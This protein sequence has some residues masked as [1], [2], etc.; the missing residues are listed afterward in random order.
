MLLWALALAVVLTIAP[1]QSVSYTLGAV[2]HTV[3]GTFNVKDGQIRFNPSDGT[4][5]GDIV[6]DLTTGQS[7]DG[8]RDAHMQHD[9]LQTDRYPQAVFSAE[10]VDGHL[11]S[12][13]PSHLDVQGSLL[14]H[15][16]RHP[17]VLPVDVIGDH[18]RLTAHTRFTVPYAAWGMKN[19]S[20]FFLR[21]D[22]HVTI[23]VN[24]PLTLS[25]ATTP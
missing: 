20:T 13:G 3:K 8:K 14:I 9:V 6:I 19:P 7:G 23:D 1:G 24:A 12:D 18:G 5:A 4:A 10:H 25:S 17:F 16:D 22:D 2:L 21:V 11:A 15:G